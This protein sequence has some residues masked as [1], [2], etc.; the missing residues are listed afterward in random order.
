MKVSLDTNILHQEGFTSQNM[1]VL[2]RLA[3]AGMVDIYVAD[4]VLREHDSKRVSEI[5]SKLQS[6]NQGLQDISKHFSKLGI[7]SVEIK[8]IESL[9]KIVEEELQEKISRSTVEWMNS[10]KVTRISF[11][12]EL[13]SKIWDDYFCGVGAFKKPK[14]RDDIPDAVIG[15][16]ITDFASKTEG[17]AI[18]CKDT[19]LKCHL[20]DTSNLELYDDLAEFV[21]SPAVQKSLSELDSRNSSIERIKSIIDSDLFKD[22]V[23]R[24]ISAEESDLYYACWKGDDVEELHRLP[25]P[26]RGE[27]IIGGPVVETISGVEF[28][29]VSCIGP[30][31]YV[32]PLQFFA[33]MPIC[34]AASYMDWVHLP[35]SLKE[36]VEM[37]SM[38]GDGVCDFYL[39]KVGRVVGQIVIHFLEDL[40]AESVVVHAGYIGHENCRLDVEYVA[41]KVYLMAEE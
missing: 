33:E 1:Q 32:I 4:L 39:S 13:Y 10:C 31:H 7:E 36:S 5:S 23:M 26:I 12:A 38:G 40:T 28:G 29:S 34:F 24:Y 3:A 6:I 2:A 30:K 27:I 22:A 21:A 17:M 18:I 15:L 37:D 41:G 20:S 25:M 11:P 16:S 19:Q 9:V 14:N 8:R 35:N